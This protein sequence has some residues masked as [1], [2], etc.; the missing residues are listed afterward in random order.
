VICCRGKGKRWPI[1]RRSMRL[2]CHLGWLLPNIE[3]CKPRRVVRFIE[4][5]TA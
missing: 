4:L 5:T 3:P 2:I 1:R